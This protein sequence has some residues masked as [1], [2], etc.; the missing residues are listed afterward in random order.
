[1]LRDNGLGKP[2]RWPGVKGG[3]QPAYVGRA[4]A[5]FNDIRSWPVAGPAKPAFAVA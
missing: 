1:M 2:A 4:N 5:G 3:A